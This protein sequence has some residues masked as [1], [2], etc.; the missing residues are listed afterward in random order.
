MFIFA[1]TSSAQRHLAGSRTN[2]KGGG[3]SFRSHH[4]SLRNFDIFSAQFWELSGVSTSPLRP[5]I[6]KESNSIKSLLGG[7]PIFCVLDEAQVP[8]NQCKEYFRS[9]Q[10]LGIERPLLSQVIED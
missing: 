2:T 3:F 5:L 9:R 6:R 8:A 1:Y 4:G 7:A 10:D